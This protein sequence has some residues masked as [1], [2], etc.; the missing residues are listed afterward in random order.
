MGKILIKYDEVYIKTTEL[1]KYIEAN[2]L[3]GVDREYQQIQSI[4][5]S[6]DGAAAAK[7]KEVMETNRQKTAAAAKTLNKL[8]SFMANSTKQVELNEQKI[9]NV[10]ASGAINKN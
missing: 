2:I 4:L 6:V 5:N 1:K 9:A 7:L 3:N 8:L 10:M